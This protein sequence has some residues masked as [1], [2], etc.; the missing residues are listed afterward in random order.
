MHYHIMNIIMNNIIPQKNTIIESMLELYKNI[1]I[2]NKYDEELN[3]I[4]K[5]I[6]RIDDKKTLALDLVLD[7]ELKREELKSQFASY[8]VEL[9]RLARDKEN[10]LK[11]VDKIKENNI[12]IDKMSK[13]IQEEIEGGSLEEFIRKFVDEI[14]V[15]KIDED[16]YNI[17]LDI[18]LNLF[19]EERPRI[20]GAR[21]IDG[22]K[23]DEILYLEKQ[24]CDSIEIVRSDRNMNKFTYNVYVKTL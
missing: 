11:E 2:N 1:D 13:S 3:S 6:K 24:Q 23:E 10:I 5:S 14:I 7:G 9:K 18:Y 19:A 22:P 16:R 21:H 20:K 15:S 17:I 12:N 8:E 4:E